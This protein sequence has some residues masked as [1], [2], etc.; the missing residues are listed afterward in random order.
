MA[1]ISKE[2]KE[3]RK[4]EFN[5]THMELMYCQNGDG[6]QSVYLND[7]RITKTKPYGFSTELF[8]THI[9]IETLKRVIEEFENSQEN[10]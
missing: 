9:S 4:K 5:R 8:K 3:R 10:E 6:V 2:E 1:L 7:T